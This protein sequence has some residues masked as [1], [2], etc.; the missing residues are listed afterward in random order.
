MGRGGK[1]AVSSQAGA[2][3]FCQSS[4]FAGI[5]VHLGISGS[6][7]CYKAADLLRT[8]LKI[9]INVSATLTS[10]AREFITPMLIRAVG[11]EPVYSEMFQLEGVFAH[12]EPGQRADCMLLAPASAN[13]L[14]R[15]A[16]GAAAD[17]LAAQFLAFTGPVVI[18]PAMNPRMWAHAATQANVELLRARGAYFVGPGQGLTACGETGTGRLA[19]LSEIFLATLKALSPNDMSGLK[20]LVTMGPTREYWDGVRFWSNPST[21]KMG[22]ALATSAWLRGANVTALCGPGV[23]I[24]LPQAIHKIS[25]GSAREMYTEAGDLWPQMD[26]GLF[27]AAVADF[28]P[29]PLEMDIKVKKEGM[30]ETFELAFKRNPDILAS[31]AQN[32]RPQQKVLGF[33]AEIG[34]DLPSLLPLVKAKLVKKQSDIVAGNLVNEGSGA[35]G[36]DLNSMVVVDK[37]GREEIWSQQPKADIA[38]E[39]LT[40][41]LTI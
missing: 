3:P 32:R 11:A 25:V 37:K 16:Q 31:L 30:G 12:L 13:L 19:D 23:N 8:F 9:G 26:M 41:L 35:F 34:Q 7:A 39:L 28:A 36:A 38:W 14:S 40:W 18:A 22:A 21:G 5:N 17:M 24:A 27:C 1:G 33:A 4:R 10:G 2:N 29:V 20:V 6:I 15:L